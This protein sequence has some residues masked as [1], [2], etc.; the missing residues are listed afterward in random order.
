[1]YAYVMDNYIITGGGTGGHIYPAL[2]VANEI[3][4]QDS[5]ARIILIGARR[6]LEKSLFFEAGFKSH[7]IPVGQF[8]SSVGRWTQLKTLLLLPI[9]FLMSFWFLVKYR[10][11]AVL[12]V[13][14]YASAP[15]CVLSS[16]LGFKTY[17]WE[18]NATPGLSNKV[19]GKFKAVPLLV[20][21]EAKKFFKSKEAKIVG[22]PVRQGLDGVAD[23]PLL[24][25]AEKLK[26][27]QNKFAVLFVGGSQGASVFNKL[28]PDLSE[29]MPEVHFIHQTGLKNYESTKS[30][31]YSDTTSEVLAYLDPIKEF[32]ERADLVVCRSGA[33]TL[34]ELS[35]LGKPCLLIP[36]PKS[37]DDHQVKN[38][39]SL[40][41]KGAALMLKEEDVT[42]E[43]L[44]SSL[45]DLVNNE[46][47]L[48]KMKE[49]FLGTFPS[50]AREEIASILMN[51]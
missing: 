8:H 41:D 34:V 15:V 25:E 36:F 23:K 1:M 49:A 26:K 38:A 33:S 11:K 10:P 51:S 20:F 45:E 50:G 14:G 7:F 21:K 48:S 2:A 18:A 44:K 4:M 12:G 37:S 3:K 35:N 30:K 46:D 32:Y 16:I 22:L 42:L 6:G 13:G 17:V 31:Y 28:V 24:S 19:V 40:V 9:C 29:M 5:N 47:K 39:Q 27:N 43:S